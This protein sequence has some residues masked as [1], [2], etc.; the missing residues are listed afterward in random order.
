[1]KL[2]SYLYDRTIFWSGHRHARYF[3]A[4]VSFAESS[5]FPIPPDV[6]LISMGLASPR[7]SWR[8]AF[9][10]TVFSVLGGLFGYLL[11]MYFMELIQ[12]YLLSSSYAGSYH[13]IVHWF[14]HSGVGVVILAGFTPFP[15]KIFTIT[16]GAMNMA[17]L[18]FIIGSII[19]RGL[20]FYLVASLLYFF[21]NRIEDRIRK[22]V[23]VLGWSLLAIIILVV[24]AVKFTSFS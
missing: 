18:P 7:N 5:F 23:D 12:P 4:G 13:R 22:Y 17:I 19:G 11:G 3:L 6:M 10:A 20:R 21:G 14:E 15:Y 16:A 8:N 1:L 9:I 2:F 24:I